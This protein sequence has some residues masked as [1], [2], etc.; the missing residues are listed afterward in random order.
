VIGSVRAPDK[1]GTGKVMVTLSCPD[2]KERKVES[3]T[4]ELPFKNK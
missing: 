3:V 4:C 2:V 1:I